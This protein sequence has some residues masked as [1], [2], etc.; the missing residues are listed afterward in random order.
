MTAPRSSL[1]EL[2]IA[3]SSLLII[4]WQEP[5]Q[6]SVKDT[7]GTISSKT[8]S[9]TKACLDRTSGTYPTKA[10]LSVTHSWHGVQRIQLVSSEGGL[11]SY[12]WR[13]WLSLGYYWRQCR[14]E[15]YTKLDQET[16]LVPDPIGWLFGQNLDFFRPYKNQVE[17]GCKGYPIEF[18]VNF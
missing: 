13:T 8:K 14:G 7:S 9:G 16:W 11:S 18:I 12:S 10:K 6:L 5:L 15:N 17:P 1:M 3:S 4:Y 2:K